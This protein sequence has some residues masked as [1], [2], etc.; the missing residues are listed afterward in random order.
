M[1]KRRHPTI[2]KCRVVSVRVAKQYPEE[3]IDAGALPM[4]LSE[5]SK[6]AVGSNDSCWIMY[7]LFNVIAQPLQNRTTTHKAVVDAGLLP[8]IVDH[9]FFNP[10]V[11]QYHLITQD[12]VN[13]RDYVLKMM[14]SIVTIS[15]QYAPAILECGAVAKCCA[16]FSSVELKGGKKE[17]KQA[18]HEA[19]KIIIALQN[20]I[21]PENTVHLAIAQCSG[22][23]RIK[24]LT[25]HMDADVRKAAAEL[26]SMRAKVK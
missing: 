10:V 21:M 6:Q 15:P 2:Q 19:L 23:S 1:E 17:A 24:R 13:V 12:A 16:F 25:G 4:L 5:I 18:A 14:N 22:Y 9:I 7:A 3:V 8:I 20:I 26:M 11:A